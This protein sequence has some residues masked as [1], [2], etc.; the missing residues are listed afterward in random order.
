[1]TVLVLCAMIAVAFAADVE[2]EVDVDAEKPKKRAVSA[3]LAVRTLEKGHFMPKHRIVYV[4]KGDPR[5]RDPNPTIAPK[6]TPFSA[7]PVLRS[8]A[9]ATS[10]ACAARRGTCKASASCTGANTVVHGLCSGPSS[11]T[12]CVPGSAPSTPS[13]PSTPSS[14]CPVYA[15]A[16]TSQIKGNGGVMYTVVRI[17]P[18][19]FSGSA[20]NTMTKPTACAFAQMAEAA[21]RAGIRLT[22]NSGFRTYDR[23]VYFWN[24]FQTKR[25]NNGNTA[26]RPGTSNH[27]RGQALDINTGATTTATYRWM[28]ANA[29][30]FGFRRTVSNEPWHWEH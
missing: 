1:V 8:A 27:G 22:I 12:C 5:A 15:N 10:S 13:T 6:V 29:S 18:Q 11:I 20:D 9:P 28:A 30:R 16:P 21:A 2:T 26:A 7:R 3:K 17:A 4:P 14:S 19:H 23:Q 25:C 24:C